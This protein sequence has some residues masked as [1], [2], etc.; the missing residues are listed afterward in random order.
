MRGAEGWQ[1][2]WKGTAVM[3]ILNVT[4]DSFS[5]GGRHASL[6]AA[7][8]AAQAMHAAGVLMV[9]IG[10]ESTRPGAEPVPAEQEIDRVR[11]VVAALRDVGVL[12][13]VDTLKP[14]V[15]EAALAAGAHLVND[16]GGLRDPA[17]RA[18]CAAYGAPACIMH[19]QGEPRTMQRDP[20]YSDVVA[21]VSAFLQEQARLALGAG[22]PDVLLDPGLGFGKTLDHNLTLLRALPAM[23]AGPHPVLVGA[24]R[25]RLI[26]WLA[27]VPAAEDRDPGT[28]ALHLHAARAGAA[29]VRAHAGAAHVQALRV[30]AAL[31][32][33]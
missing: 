25:K 30:Q 31:D 13:S 23:C 5:D 20:Q 7:V 10:G 11:P 3:G 21:E 18:V 2:G 32:H 8:A 29:V 15:A 16:V 26:D 27:Q 33:P 22:V 19:M 4:P 14:E 24:S 12:L 17:M 9:D 6:G 1:V 28:L